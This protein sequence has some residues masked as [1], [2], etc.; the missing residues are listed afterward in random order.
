MAAALA[1]RRHEHVTFNGA[2]A[3]ITSWYSGPIVAVVPANA[4]TR[5]VVVTVA[6]VA[7]NGVAFTMPRVIAGLSANTGLPG[8]SVT[9]SGSNFG[10]STGM[11]TFNGQSATISSWSNTSIVAVVPSSVS[12]VVVPWDTCLSW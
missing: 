10:N 3:S 2:P 9:I 1:Q 12:V 11:V 6:G 4:S 5:N 7:S 8:A